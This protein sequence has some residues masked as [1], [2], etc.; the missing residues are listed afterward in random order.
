VGIRGVNVLRTIATLAVIL[1]VSLF[2]VVVVGYGVAMISLSG[3]L[4][5]TTRAID[6]SGPTSGRTT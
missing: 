5:T 1:L 2:A 6:W 4:S 3:G